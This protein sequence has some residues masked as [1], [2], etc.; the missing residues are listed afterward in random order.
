MKNSKPLYFVF[1][2]FFWENKNFIKQ[3][4][5]KGFHKY[6]C[7][8]DSEVFVQKFSYAEAAKESIKR[9]GEAIWIQLGEGE[10]SFRGKWLEGA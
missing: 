10:S 6:S 5:I 3:K 1:V 9:V 4:Q 2:F 7:V 8:I